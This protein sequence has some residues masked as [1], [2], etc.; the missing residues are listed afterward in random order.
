M[1]KFCQLVEQTFSRNSHS[2]RKT[3]REK[4]KFLDL[5][6]LPN[7]PNETNI[8]KKRVKANVRNKQFTIQVGERVKSENLVRK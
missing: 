7:E 8:R 2:P 1:M 5:L 3:F 6:F 4:R